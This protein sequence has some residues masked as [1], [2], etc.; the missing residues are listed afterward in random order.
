MAK[1]DPG[2]YNKLKTFLLN[3]VPIREVLEKNIKKVKDFNFNFL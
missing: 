3:S 1:T 2:N